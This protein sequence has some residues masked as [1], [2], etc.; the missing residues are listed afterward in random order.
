MIVVGTVGLFGAYA[1][2][3]HRESIFVP[4]I[5][6]EAKP[7]QR[8]STSGEV[9]APDMRSAAITAAEADVPVTQRL[10][11]TAISEPPAVVEKK[12]EAPP[13]KRKVH[14]ARRPVPSAAMGYAAEPSFYHPPAPFGGW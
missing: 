14:A 11:Q 13:K 8:W 3:V 1:A 7:V 12:A 9:P 5:A 6:A 4:T 10:T 2:I